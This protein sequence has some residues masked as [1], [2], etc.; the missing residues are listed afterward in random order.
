MDDVGANTGW[1]SVG[2]DHAAVAFAVATLRSSWQTVGQPSY[3]AEAARLLVC[4]DPGCSNGSRLRLWKVELANLAAETGL[5]IIV[6]HL[7]PRHQQVEQDR[8][9]PV[10]SH[11]HELARG[12]ESHESSSTSS[13]ATTTRTGLTVHA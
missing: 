2:K 4:A 1:V 10:G 12:R 7:P 11:L 8:S 5:T 6:C 9:P 3:R 13:P